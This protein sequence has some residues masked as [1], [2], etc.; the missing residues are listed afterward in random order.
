MKHNSFIT[1]LHFSAL[2][3]IPFSLTLTLLAFIYGCSSEKPK[4]QEQ[5]VKVTVENLQTAY[6][7]ATKYVDMY[8]KFSEKAQQEKLPTIAKLFTAVSHSEKIHADQHAALL[9][10]LGGEP[11]QPQPD[12]IPVGTTLQTLK[13]SV[14]M[15]DMEVESMYANLIRTAEMENMPDAVQQFMFCKEGDARQVELLKEVLDK[16]GKIAK[17]T[18]YVCPGCGYI[19]TTPTEECTICKTKSTSFEKI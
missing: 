13:M 12:P 14:S 2:I 9:R 3:S 4:Q 10:K 19:S 5:V 16:S 8:V 18:Y 17:V 6:G 15:E 1:Q 11:K 7:K